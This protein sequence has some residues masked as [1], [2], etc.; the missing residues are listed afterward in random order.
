MAAAAECEGWTGPTRST[1]LIASAPARRNWASAMRQCSPRRFSTMRGTLKYRSSP[2]RPAPE[3]MRWPSVTGTAVCSGAI[4][5]SSKSR[6]RRVFQTCCA[7][8]YIRPRL[9]CARGSACAGWPPSS[10]W[11]SMT[12][13]SFW[14]STRESKSN[15]PS[16]RK[17]PESIWWPP[18]SPS[19]VAR[20]ITSW[21]YLPESPP[22]V[23]KSSA[24]PLPG[25]AA[26][27][28]PGSTL[29]LLPLT[30]H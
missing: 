7:T 1:S 11:L 6:Q 30:D 18:S 2:R 25:G 27:F 17:S 22:T 5:R 8:S 24:S 15:T 13:T 20:P 12:S 16:P 28:R 9:G 19:R 3:R 23:P 21:G 26:R 29:K 10:F 14:R 4:R